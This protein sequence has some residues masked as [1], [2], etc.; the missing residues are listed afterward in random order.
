V[1][2]GTRLDI[3]FI[4]TLVFSL[5]FRRNGRDVMKSCVC[6]DVNIRYSC[7]ILM[8]IEFSW[9]IFKNSQMFGRTDIRKLVVAFRNFAKAFKKGRK[10]SGR[11]KRILEL[12]LKYFKSSLTLSVTDFLLRFGDIFTLQ[13]TDWFCIWDTI[14]VHT[15]TYMKCLHQSRQSPRIAWNSNFDPISCPETSLCNYKRMPRNI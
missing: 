3:T 12:V 10:R 7:S 5:I 6:V 13:Q 11:R 1:V 8:R 9:Q 4:T 2:A 14:T 15:V